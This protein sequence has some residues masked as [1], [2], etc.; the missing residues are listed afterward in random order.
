VEAL[1]RELAELKVLKDAGRPRAGLARGEA[2]VA[3]A[4]AIGYQPA[5]AEA[6]RIL[7]TLQEG[8]GDFEQVER[9]GKETL[10]VALGTRLDDIAQGS[11]ASL[12][13]A[14]GFYRARYEDAALWDALEESILT[15]LGP[16]HDLQWGYLWQDR[17]AILQKRGILGPARADLEK[18]LE[19]KRKA[20]GPDHVE[21]GRALNTIGNILLDQGDYPG[22]LAAIDAALERFTRSFGP[23]HP[24]L[25]PPLINYGEAL[26]GLGR[27]GEALATFRRC[28]ALGEP[29]LGI[30]HPLL[31]Y[32]LTGIGV[33][34]LN[35]GDI[36]GATQALERALAL[37]EKGEPDPVPLADTR[38][39]LARVMWQTGERERSLMLA[40]TA[41]KTYDGSPGL[42]RRLAE[43]DAW[44][45]D[46]RLRPTPTRRAVVSE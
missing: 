15:R 41:R 9:T 25:V 34:L 26:Q 14:A 36:A 2:A 33:A 27:T 7:T 5:L 13:E 3:K 18:A 37:R 20:L 32:P 44:L 38:F 42:A 40:S 11:T 10:W 22:A 4:R 23:D 31:A 16:G 43:A 45:G 12:L 29:E 28:F 24:D 21:V 17:G 6:L 35:Q 19:L 1:R 8:V 46:H 30:D 39:A